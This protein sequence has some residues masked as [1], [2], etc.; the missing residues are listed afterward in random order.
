MKEK[1]RYGVS[2]R[3]YGEN[4]AFGP[5]IA[6]L[7]RRIEETG[8]L[9]GAAASMNMAYSKAWKILKET[10]GEWGIALTNRETGGRSGGGSTLTEEA[11]EIL[12]KYEAFVREAERQ[13]DLLFER[14]FTPEWLKDM[15][16]RAC[17]GE[18][19]RKR[20][21]EERK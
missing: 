18:P 8:S 13:M 4:K 3:L 16:G 12:G 6:C 21:R 2:I 14:E 19:Q 20:E 15:E 11:K 10:E 7:L 17:E 9:Q 1:L 5:G